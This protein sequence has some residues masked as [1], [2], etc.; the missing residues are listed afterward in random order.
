MWATVSQT[1][2]QQSDNPSVKTFVLCLALPIS[3]FI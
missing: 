3:L 2:A 1:A